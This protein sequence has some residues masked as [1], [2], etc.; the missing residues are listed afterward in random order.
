M[1]ARGSASKNPGVIA[2]GNAMEKK[3]DALLA[4]GV[5][6]MDPAA[7]YVEDRVTVGR[8]SVLLPGTI[9]RGDT[10]V[11]EGCTIGPTR[12]LNRCRASSAF[13]MTL[14]SVLRVP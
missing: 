11:G 2:I 9:L 6:M 10:R 13:L 1:E 5:I 7:V 8:G 14:Y 12:A 3:R 4:Q